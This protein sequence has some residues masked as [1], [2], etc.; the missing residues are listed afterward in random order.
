MHR[1]VM[2]W[3]QA[4]YTADGAGVSPPLQWKGVP[5]AAGSV[6]LL[7][8]DADSPTRH[9]LVHAIAYDLSGHRMQRGALSNPRGISVLAQMRRNS[10]HGT[11]SAPR[12]AAGP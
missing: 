9:P 11:L 2:D 12:S 5:D 6:V 10:F 1:E 3:R 8:E 7:V 4:K